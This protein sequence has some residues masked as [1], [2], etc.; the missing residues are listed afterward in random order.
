MKFDKDIVIGIAICA[1]LL[2]GWQP[3]CTYMGWTEDAPAR[4]QETA[5]A[6]SQ[7]AAPAAAN[8]P[9][10]TG[11]SVTV[12][13]N[14][15]PVPQIAVKLP[16]M[17]PVVLQNED[18]AL[19]ISPEKGM[20]TS[21]E[22][23][24]YKTA[25]RKGNVILA[26]N[27]IPGGGILAVAEPGVKWEVGGIPESNLDGT[28]Y[29]L[30]RR[31]NSPAGTFL[32]RQ[33][34]QLA[35]SGYKTEYSFTITNIGLL[36][37]ELKGLTVSGGMLPPW[38][39]ISG[40]K[41]RRPAHVLD[42]RTASGSY[43]DIKA[44]KSDAKFFLRPEPSV[45]W[46]AV[47]NKYFCMILHSGAPYTLLQGR[48]YIAENVPAIMAGAEFGPFVMAPAEAFT[49]DFRLYSG[50]KIIDNLVAFNETARP[51]MHLAWGPLD[52]LAR[53][54]LWILNWFH[55]WTG[56]YGISI[57]LLTLLVRTL[58]YPVTA[59]ANVSMRKMQAVQPKLTALRA[60]YKDNPQMLNTKMMELYRAEGVNPLGGCLPIILQIPVFFALYETLDCAVELRQASF[61]WCRD[62]AAADTVCTIP[63]G[64]FDLPIN[65]LV[66]AMTVLMV[67]QQRMTPMSMDPMQKKMMMFM[68]IVMLIFLY[69]LPSGLTLYWTVSNFFSIIQMRLQQRDRSIPV[70][71]P[72]SAAA[73]PKKGK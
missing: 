44:D 67:I 66:I 5:P 46:S 8:T 41:E 22:L 33:K 32:L 49:K 9:Q 27:D 7:S 38:S 62:L 51:V 25:D 61:L 10:K 13:A 36:P 63:L 58:F 60:Q 64:F 12:P 53:L 34:W 47:S 43:D 3:L 24:H 40:D 72:T 21:L 50:P 71:A 69:D 14:P 65:P 26:E 18:L 59:R 11:V 35:K 28:T 2:F 31:I 55:S 37:L 68:P 20:V 73:T 70:A 57:I 48:S 17:K 56:S 29:T 23:K 4:T 45:D 39:F 6:A 30:T 16:D 52:Y 42:F 19:T 15:I 1:V 54:L